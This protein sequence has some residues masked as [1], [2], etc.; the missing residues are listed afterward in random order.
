MMS[1]I[2]YLE[3][4][5]PAK[6]VTV[7]EQETKIGQAIRVLSEQGTYEES[8]AAAWE[9]GQRV[10]LVGIPESIGVRA[11][12]G[13]AGAD[14]GWQ[15]FLKSFLNL[16]KTGLLSTHEM[17]LVGAVNCDDLNEKAAELDATDAHD[18]ATLRE[19]CA[20][21]DARVEKILTPLFEQGFEVIVIGGGHNNAYP[22]LKSLHK[23]TEEACGAVNL[24]PHADFRPREGRHSGN[25][26]S[27]AYME[28]ALEFYHIVG[29]H[30]GKNSASSLRQLQDAGMRYHTLH[31][32]YERP[33][34]EVMDEVVAKAVSWQR[35]L[36]IEVDVDALNAVPA[37]AVNYVGLSLGQG[38]QYVKRLAEVNE[39]RYLHLAEAAPS[40]CS[41]GFDEGMKICGQ[42]LSELTTAYLHGRERRR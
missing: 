16:Q 38:F 8:L 7:R 32:L 18:L 13:R 35:P 23:V 37:S 29:L 9:D 36:G 25:G 31:R 41:T 2:S 40:L 20:Q 26:F 15:A 1:D 27:Y 21:V 6:W 5:D 42:L 22:L 10:A 34:V 39:A 12:L 14:D 17:L 28:G 33:F 11:N 24:D 19:L 30:Q 4:T 3:L